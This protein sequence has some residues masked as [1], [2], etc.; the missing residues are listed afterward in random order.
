M[1]VEYP[2]EALR[3]LAN[4]QEIGK[5]KKFLMIKAGESHLESQI[6]TLLQR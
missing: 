6:I 5:G 1:E 2:N 4:W 3:D